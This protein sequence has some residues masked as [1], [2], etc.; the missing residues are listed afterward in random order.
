MQAQ[1]SLHKIALYAYHGCLE[2]EKIVGN[3]YEIDINVWID[4]TNAVES[5]DVADTVNYATMYEIVKQEM[6]IPSNL[7]EHVAGRIIKSIKREFPQIQMVEIRIAKMPPPISGK[8]SAAS[9]TI[10]A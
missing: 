8:I 9:V 2:Q 5:D 1:I 7:L 10:K 6:M 4:V 3:N